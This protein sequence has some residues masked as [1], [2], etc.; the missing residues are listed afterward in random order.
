MYKIDWGNLNIDLDAD[1]KLVN[2][3]NGSIIKRDKFIKAK[4]SKDIDMSE[5]S[6]CPKKKPGQCCAF[7]KDGKEEEEG[8]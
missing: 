2:M 7:S 8:A 3:V 1:K 4:K 6:Y 5:A